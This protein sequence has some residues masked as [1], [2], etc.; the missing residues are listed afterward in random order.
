MHETSFGLGGDI[1][2]GTPEV[3]YDSEE[4]Q[5]RCLGNRSERESLGGQDF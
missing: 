4:L 5:A 2:Y 3:E 1:L